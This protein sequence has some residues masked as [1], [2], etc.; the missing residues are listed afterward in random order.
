MS[1]DNSEQAG[2]TLQYLYRIKQEHKH[3]AGRLDVTSAAQNVTNETLQKLVARMIQV[4]QQSAQFADAMDQSKQFCLTTCAELS[5]GVEETKAHVDRHYLKTKVL[6]TNDHEK[7]GR[8]KTFLGMI[9]DVSTRLDQQEQSTILLLQSRGKLNKRRDDQDLERQV[10]TLETENRDMRRELETMRLQ[11]VQ[12]AMD[13]KKL[14]EELVELKQQRSENLMVK[15]GQLT[16]AP[17]VLVPASQPEE[18]QDE[19]ETQSE[20]SSSQPAQ[21]RKRSLAKAQ[22]K[23]FTQQPKI[24]QPT[25]LLEHVYV[26]RSPRNHPESQSST[27]SRRPTRVS[28]QASKVARKRSPEK[29][30]S[31]LQA[32]ALQFAQ[33]HTF[34]PL[35]D[36]QPIEE[37]SRQLEPPEQKAMSLTQ[38][39]TTRNLVF[40]YSD[41]QRAR[42]MIESI[43]AR[44]SPARPLVQTTNGG[45]S[46]NITRLVITKSARS[47]APEHPTSSPR[48]RKSSAAGNPERGQVP[49]SG[50]DVSTVQDH[51]RPEKR[52][53]VETRRST[54]MEAQNR[55]QTQE[56][57][58][59]MESQAVMNPSGLNPENI[60]DRKQT[61]QGPTA[62][63]RRRK[64]RFLPIYELPPLQD[65]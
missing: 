37:Q 49:G 38:H 4:E 57:D 20:K 47:S 6:E 51:P 21:T 9:Q 64:K 11:S 52:R 23:V 63:K 26:R 35:R 27:A 44:S 30:P 53:K 59:R 14:Q 5:K 65:W 45:P 58:Y 17:T 22:T 50:L 19:D 29:K 54:Q 3:I 55:K 28:S 39:P 7:D 31:E 43:F 12:L 48:K 13:F 62:P 56:S 40:R 34:A 61:G 16:M 32:Q 46:S 36:T 60:Q 42:E 10:G 25:Q 8:L 24:S 41:T 18:S 2:R 15:S 33:G 1:F